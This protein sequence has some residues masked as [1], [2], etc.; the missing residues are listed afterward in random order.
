MSLP[1]T[2]LLLGLDL[3]AMVV[4]GML[5]RREKRDMRSRTLSVR[6]IGRGARGP[7]RKSAAGRHLAKVLGP[8]PEIQ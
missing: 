4:F 7:Y 2:E 5:L 6:R 3:A 8:L 1:L